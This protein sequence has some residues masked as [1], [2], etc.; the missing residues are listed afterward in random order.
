MYLMEIEE[1]RAVKK[2]WVRRITTMTSGHAVSRPE[3]TLNVY[4]YKEQAQLQKKQSKR[5]FQWIKTQKEMH[6]QPWLAAAP[7]LL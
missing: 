7:S 2:L 5:K 4:T 1:T 6:W 3:A